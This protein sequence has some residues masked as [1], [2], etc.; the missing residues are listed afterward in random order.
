MCNNAYSSD[1]PC[2]ISEWAGPF[3]GCMC[4]EQH[5]H[6]WLGEF[7]GCSQSHFHFA[8]TQVAT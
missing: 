5:M 7:W 4:V 8:E 3:A 2:G 6:G 1:R